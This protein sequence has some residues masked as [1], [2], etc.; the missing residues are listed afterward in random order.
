M[1]VLTVLAYGEELVLL[2]LLPEWATDVRGIYWVVSKS[3]R[4]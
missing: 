1:T 2:F 4:E 3:P